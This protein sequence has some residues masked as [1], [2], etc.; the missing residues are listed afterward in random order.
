MAGNRITIEPKGFKEAIAALGN[1]KGEARSAIRAAVNRTCSFVRTQ[2]VKSIR[3]QYVIPAKDVRDSIKDEKKAT[4]S[5]L[6][7]SLAVRSSMTSIYPHFRVTPKFRPTQRGKK[8]KV[9]VTIKKGSRQ[10]M[11]GRVFL[12]TATSTKQ[13]AQI[14]VRRAGAKRKPVVPLHTLSVAQMVNDTVQKDIQAQASEMLEKRVQHEL[15]YSL[16]KLAEKHG[17]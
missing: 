17:M 4:N 7:A 6:V 12:P 9:K 5:N 15:E 16:E 10:A 11:Q 13:K 3:A 1:V 14:W 8:Y 2:L